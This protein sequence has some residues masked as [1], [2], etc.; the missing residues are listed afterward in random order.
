MIPNETSP[1]SPGNSDITSRLSCAVLLS[2]LLVSCDRS[3]SGN[4]QADL[5]TNPPT[6]DS[7]QTR[8]SESDPPGDSGTPHPDAPQYHG[9]T[10]DEW[11][12][13]L[14]EVSY[15]DPAISELVPGLIAIVEDR[16]GAPWYSRRQAAIALGRIGEPA[17]AAV[18]TMIA[19]LEE[20][21]SNAAESTKLWAIK[22]LSLFGPLASEATPAL[23]RL[24]NDPEQPPL[25]R[26]AAIEALGRIGPA[27]PDALPAVIAVLESSAEVQDGAAFERRVAAAEILELVGDSAA[28]AVPALMK[29]AANQSELLRRAAVNTLGMIGPLAEPAVPLLVDIMIFDESL[30]VRDLAATALG[31]IGRTG[32]RALAQLLADPELDVRQRAANG[33]DQLTGASE[34][35][36]Q[37]LQSATTDE[38]AQVRIAAAAALWKAT[39]DPELVVPTAL[40]GLT[41]EEREARMQAVVLLRLIGTRASPWLPELQTLTEDERHYVRQAA[42]RAVRGIQGEQ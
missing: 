31:R 3:E 41:V 23:V 18:P 22:S 19:L 39:A 17:R 27:H 34:S 29:A 1:T 33:L 7:V 4:Q 9:R 42:R 5:S 35:T 11:R 32:E 16:E 2:V 28:A 15:D 38:S 37:R 14:K 40:D 6:V 20:S 24:L 26:L 10:L 21:D 12:M 13:L 25:P 8:N 30:D 36:I